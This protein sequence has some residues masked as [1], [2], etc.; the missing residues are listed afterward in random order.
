MYR[1][2]VLTLALSVGSLA[3]GQA[4]KEFVLPPGTTIDL[5]A[6]EGL[7]TKA[8]SIDEP[9]IFEVDYPIRAFR[10]GPVLI[11]RHSLVTARVASANRPGRF[12]GKA[13]IEFT[14]ESIMIPDGRMYP[15]N[16]RLIKVRGHKVDSHGRLIGRS[17]AKRDTFFILFPP[18]TL[19]QLALLPARGPDLILRPETRLTIKLL[20]PV[21]IH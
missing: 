4:D 11:P 21:V 18:T 12:V 8:V 15:I 1:C 5:R 14:F 9:I 17:H 20:R 16:A 19:F 3:F 7:T 2:I 13:N 10:V 6:G